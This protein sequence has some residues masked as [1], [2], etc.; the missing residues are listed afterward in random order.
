MRTRSIFLS[1]MLLGITS[2]AGAQS[3]VTGTAIQVRGA[4]TGKIQGVVFDSLLMKPIAGAM[5][6]L[7]GRADPVKADSRGRFTFENLSA[8]E[9]TIM[10]STP[11][12]DSLG[13][14]TMGTTLTLA[15]EVTARITLATPSLRTLWQ[16][17]C[18][19]GTRVGTDSGIVWGTI[20]DAATN[21]PLPAAAATFSWYD[22]RP[23]KAAG[24]IIDDVRRE[25]ITDNA[26]LFFACG[27]PTDVVVA[28]EAIDTSTV[29]GSAASGHLEYAIGSRGLQHLDLLVSKDMVLPDSV[30]G[31]SSGDSSLMER[32]RGTAMLKGK[33]VDDRDRPVPDAIVTVSSADTSVRTGKDGLFV[34]GGLPGG[35]QAMQTKRIGITQVSQMVPLRPDSVTEVTVRAVAYN[36]ASVYNVR[37][38]RVKGA[39]R[40]EYETRRKMG[41]GIFVD[42]KQIENR[43]DVASVLQSFPGLEVRQNGFNLEVSSK[44]TIGGRCTPNVFVDGMPSDFTMAN[45]YKPSDFRA[46]EVY[47]H[48]SS[49]PAQYS[50]FAACGRSTHRQTLP[51]EWGRSLTFSQSM[52]TLNIVKESLAT[53]RGRSSSR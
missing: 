53:R 19:A 31:K 27:V 17:R 12:L 24:L 44:A 20:R 52:S 3:P 11:E 8:G 39:D 2:I 35:T 7:L 14:G 46:I 42:T 32:A 25:V 49:V 26:G 9:Q 33:V 51:C 47:L 15:E 23:R 45:I 6:T 29:R 38:Q 48:A 43:I 28:S 21:N 16:R 13:L 50:S 22:L 40:L 34:I 10:F 5:V 4:G 41:F 37:A 1:V 30:A 36:T 18:I